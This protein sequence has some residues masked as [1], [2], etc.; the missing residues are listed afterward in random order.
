MKLKEQLKMLGY[1]DAG[2]SIQNINTEKILYSFHGNNWDLK[3]IS[4]SVLNM[5]I[6]SIDFL[7]GELVIW[8]EE[9][10]EVI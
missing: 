3:D 4:D 5:K 1:I 9:Q 6:N 7:Y 10:E 2:L 8:V